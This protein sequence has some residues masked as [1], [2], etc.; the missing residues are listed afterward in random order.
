M[1][2][3]HTCIENVFVKNA[4]FQNPI[5][6]IYI[7]VNPDKEGT[8]S[9]GHI[10]HVPYH[11]MTNNVTSGGLKR[12]FYFFEIYYEN[13]RVKNCLQKPIYIG[14]QQQRQ[15]GTQGIGCHVGSHSDNCFSSNQIQVRDVVLKNVVNT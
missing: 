7:K 14:P 12:Q 5:K 4:Q 8:A 9:S 3:A 2:E 15:P 6:A 10:S 11:T 1:F 13:I